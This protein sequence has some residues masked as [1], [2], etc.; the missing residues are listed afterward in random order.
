MKLLTYVVN[1]VTK[2]VHR[3]RTV[4]QNQLHYN[5][6]PKY[7]IQYYPIISLRFCDLK[8]NEYHAPFF[9]HYNI[10][11]SSVQQIA[12]ITF[13]VYPSRDGTSAN[14]SFLLSANVA[15]TGEYK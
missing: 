5:A 1:G 9:P 14:R 4:P 2:T 15:V 6:F 12:A 3:Y 7:P 10:P 13:R 8:R 11:N